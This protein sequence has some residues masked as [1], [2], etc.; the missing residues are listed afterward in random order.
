MKSTRKECEVTKEGVSSQEGMSVKSTKKGCEANKKGGG[1]EVRVERER[2]KFGKM[3]CHQ[4]DNGFPRC[5][6]R[7]PRQ[8]RRH[9]C[10]PVL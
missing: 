7:G 5:K 8:P 1:G 3:S 10:L 9:L 2:S 6:G 4:V